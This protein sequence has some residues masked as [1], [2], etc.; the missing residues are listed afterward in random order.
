MSLNR[1]TYYEGDKLW[2]SYGSGYGTSADNHLTQFKMVDGE[3]TNEYT[4]TNLP[5]ME[6][7]YCTLYDFVEGTHSSAHSKDAEG[8]NAV[9]D[10]NAGW[11]LENGV[12]SSSADSVKEAFRLFVAPTWVGKVEGLNNYIDFTKAT[13]ETNGNALVMK[14]WVSSTEKEGK[15]LANAED[16]GVNA[17]FAKAAIVKDVKDCQ[18]VNGGFESGDLTGWTK[19]GQIGAVTNESNYWPWEDGGYSFDKDGEWLFSSYADDNERAVG[20]LKSSTFVVGGNGWITFKLGAG[21]NQSLVN[22]QVVDANTGNILKTYGNSLWSEHTNDV[23]SGCTLIP[24]KANISDLLGR[25]VYIRV[26]DNAIANYGLIFFDSL[27]TYYTNTPSDSFNTAED[28]KLGGSIYQ[29][30]NGDFERGNLDGWLSD[31]EIGVVTNADGYW[32]DNIPYD[33]H[34]DYLFTGV[35]SHGADTMREGNKGTLTSSVFEIGGSGYISFMLGG[36]GNELCYVQVIDAVTN[37]VLVRYH[38]Q[39]QQDAVLKTHVADLSSYIGRNVKIQV[40]DLASGGWGCVSFDNVVTYYDHKPE[41]ITANNIY[42]G[43]YSIV[44]G[45]FE[46][47]LDGWHMNLWEAGAHNTL[48]WVESS[49]HNADWYTKNDDRKDGNN[50]FTFVKPDGTNCENTRGELVSSTF[51]LKKDSYVSFRFGGAGT[52]AVCVELVR[53]DGTVIATFYNEAPGKMNTE[54]FAYFYQYQGE[55]TDCF[56]RVVDDSVSNYGCFVVDDFRV[57]LDSAPEGFIPAIR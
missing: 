32:G 30:C 16:D 34:G 9:L 20:Y 45:S 15:L 1:T 54:M 6:D 38:Q 52:R 23:K 28:L 4:V 7:Y 55:T 12:Y 51:T 46:N 48:G 57:N 25:E 50:L 53:V 35:E 37:E 49:E 21:R 13:V 17:V 14:L 18:V 5:G 29:V 24:Y 39:E 42:N 2:F 33:K 40:V 27:Q 44:N 56:F 41:G 36:G 31:G 3:V 19:V 22:V 8:N 47:G 26:V 43:T 10:L 11:T